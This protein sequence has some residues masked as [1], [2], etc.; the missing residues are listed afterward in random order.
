M[1]TLL[2]KILYNSGMYKATAHIS[3]DD[4]LK[5]ILHQSIDYIVLV[6]HAYQILYDILDEYY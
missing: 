4:T 2:F 1:N 3:H 6:V 5:Y